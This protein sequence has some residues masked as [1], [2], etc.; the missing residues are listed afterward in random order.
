MRTKGDI[1]YDFCYF[2]ILERCLMD[3]NIQLVTADIVIS[4][5]FK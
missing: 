1:S 4:F 3:K 5:L 2:E